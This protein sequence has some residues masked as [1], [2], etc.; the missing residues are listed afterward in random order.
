MGDVSGRNRVDLPAGDSLYADPPIDNSLYTR[1]WQPVDL[2]AVLEGSWEPPE[3]S[4]GQR[5]DGIG[6]FYPGKSHTVVSETEGGK[7]WLALSAV[8]DELKAGHRVV[9][10]DFEDDEGGIVGRLLTLGANR[11]RIRKQFRYVRPTHPLGAGIHLDDLLN[12]FKMGDDNTYADEDYTS[13]VVIDGVT[14]AMAL[15]NLDPNKNNEVAAFGRLL[16]DILTQ[17]GAA[18][19]SLDHVVK[20]REGRGRYALGG[21]HKL[22]GLDGAAYVLENRTPFGIGMKGKSTIRIAKD[23]PGQLRRH[24][25]PGPHG[26][27]W[28]GDLVLESHGDDFAE[29]SIEP[30]TERTENFRPTVLMQRISDALAEHGPLSQRRIRSAVTGRGEAVSQ[31]LDCLILDGYVSDASPHT[32]LK[33]YGTED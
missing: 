11:D 14:E 25:L 26:M 10:L 29:V 32:L 5:V 20:D 33:P 9:Y 12:H 21:V 7:T 30:P 18:V 17:F 15:H 27:H 19:V 1:S 22:N 13:L 2:E 16:P 28:Y 31:A 23:R 24:A 3:P 4:V 8:Y 6:L